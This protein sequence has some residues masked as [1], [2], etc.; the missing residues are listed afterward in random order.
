MDMEK[1]KT[2]I[3]EYFE[4]LPIGEVVN[5]KGLAYLKRM[6][7]IWDYSKW[8]YLESIHIYGARDA[9][10]YRDSDMRYG[11]PKGNAKEL[12]K[13]DGAM[14]EKWRQS[15]AH[16]EMTIGEIREKFGF[17][18]TIEVNG[19]QFNHEYFDGCF[20]A[21]LVKT[22]PANGKEVRHRLAFPAGVV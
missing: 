21:Y 9:D 2:K 12:E 8:G 14:Y 10:G 15:R 3:Q 16:T 22:G 6:G 20:N 11:F 17:D 1:K 13:Y 5:K 4:N 7:Y 18:G 19:I